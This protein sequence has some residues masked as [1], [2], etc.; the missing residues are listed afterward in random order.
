MSAGRKQLIVLS[1]P[2]GAGK[3]TLAKHLL[4]TFPQFKFSVS[5]T[6]R[7][8]RPNE[9][10]GKD[11]HFLSEGEFKQLIA[12]GGF[13]EYEQIFGNYYGTL[14]SE[15]E[16]SLQK[17]EIVVFDID[18]KGALSIKRLF[19]NE[20]FLIFISPPS[21]E[22]LKERLIKRGT[23]SPE[24]LQKRWERIQMEMEQRDKFDYVL[25]NDDLEE[26]K[27]ELIEIVQKVTGLM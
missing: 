18:V 25:V 16:K 12:N 10:D 20:S 19:P 14:K 2:S 23:E 6:T 8:P 9:V 1:A 24:Q 7:K 21:I 13:V 5:A 15:I 17:G 4:S 11:Y 3:T 26:A 27:K 22:V